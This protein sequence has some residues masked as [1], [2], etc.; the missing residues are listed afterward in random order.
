MKSFTD[1]PLGW[2][3]SRTNLQDPSGLGTAPRG[4]MWLVGKG[5]SG[6]EGACCVSS[7]DFFIDGHGDFPWI[8]SG[9]LVIAS[10]DGV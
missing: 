5:G 6:M 7:V 9:R 8:G 1:A 3:R 10:E 2:L 4:E